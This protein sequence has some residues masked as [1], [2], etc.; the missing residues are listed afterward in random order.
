MLSISLPINAQYDL[1][2]GLGHDLPPP[3]PINSISNIE[4]TPLSKEDSLRIVKRMKELDSL[5]AITEKQKA[6]ENKLLEQRWDSLNKVVKEYF[7]TIDKTHKKLILGRILVVIL[8]VNL[9]AFMA[10]WARHHLR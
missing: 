4:D 7:D 9:L 5:Y 8:S 10:L 2:L 6:I 3:P 1:E